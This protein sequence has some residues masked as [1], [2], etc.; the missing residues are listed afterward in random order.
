MIQP[1]VGLAYSF[2]SKTV[3]RAGYDMTYTHRGAVGGRGGG[4]QGT[5]ILGFSAQ[6]S[7]NSLDTYS[8]A[9]LL[10]MGACRRTSMHRSSIRR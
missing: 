7:W 10:G 3:F 5:G 4:R 9:F 1:R 8:P 6:P 2:N